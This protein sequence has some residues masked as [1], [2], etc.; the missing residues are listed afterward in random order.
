MTD[1]L[2]LLSD[3]SKLRILLLLGRKELC[4]C[5]IMGVLDMSQPLVS[6]NLS[7]LS[8]AGFLEAR[9]GGKMIYYRLRKSLPE[10][11]APL[12]KAL[13]KALEDDE[14]RKADLQ[15]LG[16]CTEYQKKTGKCSMETFLE[17]MKQKKRSRRN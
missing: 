1:A 6:R 10:P 4:V 12:V 16:D 11:L 15:S 13:R 8:R 9:R 3:S 5:Q 14:I 2:G 7:L 17:F